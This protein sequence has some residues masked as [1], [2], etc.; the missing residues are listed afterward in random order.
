MTKAV[1]RQVR[2]S[3]L[4]QMIDDMFEDPFHSASGEY[5]FNPGTLIQRRPTV[6]RENPLIGGQLQLNHERA[7]WFQFCG[8]TIGSA[9]MTLSRAEDVLLLSELAPGVLGEEDRRYLRR[10]IARG[11]SVLKDIRL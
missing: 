10:R 5:E 2:V 3:R 4:S 6:K 11:H 7:H 9:V 8:S 1:P